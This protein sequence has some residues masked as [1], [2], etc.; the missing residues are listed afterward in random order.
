MST[1]PPIPDSESL[2]NLICNNNPGVIK[3]FL[4]NEPF[5]RGSGWW[6]GAGVG[7]SPKQDKCLIISGAVLTRPRSDKKMRLLG[8][9]QRSCSVV[10]GYD[11]LKFTARRLR[12]FKYIQKKKKT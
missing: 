11:H 6:W 3:A 2:T 9:V 5:V 1:R 12:T 4:M 8:A 7:A 10:T